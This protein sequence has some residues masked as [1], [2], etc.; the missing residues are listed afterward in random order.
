MYVRRRAFPLDLVGIPAD[1]DR[2]HIASRQYCV[3]LDFTAVQPASP[4]CFSALQLEPII[5]AVDGDVV[6]HRNRWVDAVAAWN[7]ELAIDHIPTNPTR[8][9]LP[10]SSSLGRQFHRRFGAPDSEMHSHS[11]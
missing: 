5:F 4:A 1:Q 11:R 9:P 6:N 8:L 7:A 10:L 2:K 3:N